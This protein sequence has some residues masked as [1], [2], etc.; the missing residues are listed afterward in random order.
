MH[1]VSR[2]LTISI[3]CAASPS[4]LLAAETGFVGSAGIQ[5]KQLQM[6]QDFSGFLNSKGDLSATLPM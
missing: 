3:A 1:S 2:F 5:L 4:I 6:E